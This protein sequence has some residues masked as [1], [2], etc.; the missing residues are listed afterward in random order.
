MNGKG[1]VGQGLDNCQMTMHNRVYKYLL[2]E[3]SGMVYMIR[4]IGGLRV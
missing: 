3:N 2:G 1:V 4:K